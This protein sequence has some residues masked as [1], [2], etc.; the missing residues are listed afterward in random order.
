M[1]LPRSGVQA[2]EIRRE[3]LSFV[4]ARDLTPPNDSATATTLTTTPLDFA[5]E[6]ELRLDGTQEAEALLVEMDAVSCTIAGD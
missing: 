5:F 4:P 6:L 2:L 1:G 3:L